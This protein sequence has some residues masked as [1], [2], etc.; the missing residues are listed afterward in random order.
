VAISLGNIGAGR[1][2]AWVA[3]QEGLEGAPPE[4]EE[5]FIWALDQLEK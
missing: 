2:E 4:L 5:Y 3:L 1:N